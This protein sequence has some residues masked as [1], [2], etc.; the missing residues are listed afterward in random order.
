MIR[1]RGFALLEVS[2]ASLVMV[3]VTIVV[4][5]SL[6]SSAGS[7]WS[8]TVRH[9][10]TAGLERELEGIRHDF[11]YGGLSTLA[12]EADDAVVPLLDGLTY[13]NARCAP[14]A[15]VT[16]AGIEYGPAVSYAFE[17]E[18][19]ELPDGRDND[20]DGL[21][22]EGM[23]VRT[24]ANGRQVLRTGVT[25]LA[26]VKSADELSCTITLAM[27]RAGG[28]ATTRMQRIVFTIQND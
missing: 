11:E 7:A 16:D 14:V 26:F 12:T 28:R 25:A 22:D 13:D 20:G 10:L 8:S 21:I 9:D 15:N 18:P 4:V 27:G 19:R 2:L 6:D 17:L 23:L 3:G 24:D 5:R 1:Q